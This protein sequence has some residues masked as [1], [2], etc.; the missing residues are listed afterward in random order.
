MLPLGQHSGI[1][2]LK[3]RGG[4]RQNFNRRCHGATSDWTRNTQNGKAGARTVAPKEQEIATIF[5]LN[6][7]SLKAQRGNRCSQK[8]WAAAACGLAETK[9]KFA[10]AKVSLTETRI[11]LAQT[12]ESP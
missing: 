5:V 12:K 10:E 8:S 6:R 11:A 1:L 3:P 2:R 7:S 4:I 9:T